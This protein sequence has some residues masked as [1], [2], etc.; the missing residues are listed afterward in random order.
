LVHAWGRD[1]AE[2]QRIA[3]EVVIRTDGVLRAEGPDR[4][5]GTGW[6]VSFDLVVP[7]AIDLLLKTRNGGIAVADVRGNLV[8]EAQNGGISVAFLVAVQGRSR[9]R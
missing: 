4:G 1:D 5:G 8:F 7:S 2:V 6:S 3:S 9:R